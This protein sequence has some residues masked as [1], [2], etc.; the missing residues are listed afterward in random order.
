MIPCPT[1]PNMIPNNKVY[2]NETS[3]VGS[4]SLYFGTPYISTNIRNGRENQLLLSNVGGDNLTSLLAG[5]TSTVT[6]S[7]LSKSSLNFFVFLVGT[8]PFTVSLSPITTTYF[9]M[10]YTSFKCLAIV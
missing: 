10:I 7:I 2:D 3:N 6:A 5:F 8:K 9:C 4:A 1:S